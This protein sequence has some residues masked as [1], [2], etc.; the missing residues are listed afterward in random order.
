[1]STARPAISGCGG[2]GPARSAAGSGDTGRIRQAG[3]SAESTGNASAAHTA[4]IQTWWRQAADACLKSRLAPAVTASTSA[5]FAE[6]SM[7]RLSHSVA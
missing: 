6:A 1:M 2:G 3:T 4:S 5:A 7:Y